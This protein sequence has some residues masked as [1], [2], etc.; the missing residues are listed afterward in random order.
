MKQLH[1][2]S[3]RQR[4]NAAF[5][6]VSL[7]PMLLCS[8]LLLQIFRLRMTSNAQQTAQQQLSAS[9]EALDTLH[10]GFLQTAAS[11]QH[12][13]LVAQAL[14]DAEAEDAAV[15]SQL[16]GA[17]ESVRSFARFDLYDISGRWR[18]STQAAPER[19]SLPT[20]WGLLYEAACAGAGV[21][22]CSAAEDPASTDEPLLRA[23]MLLTDRYGAPVGYLTIG[24]L[25]TQLRTLLGGTAGAQNELLL[26][27][28]RWRPVYCT[29]PAQTQSLADA[30]REQ[31]LSGKALTGLSA[32]ASYTVRQ[33]TETG[34]YLVLQQPQPLSAGTLRL[35]YS[36]SALCALACIIL[37]VVLSLQLSRQVFQPIGRLH[38]AIRQVGKNDL[39]V[40]VPIPAGQ[41]DELGEL[42]QQFNSMVVA[43]RHNQQALLENQRAL[44]RAQI[45]M[46]Q[47]QLNPHFLCNTLDTM[48]WISKINQVPQVAL[49]STNLADILRFCI[50]PDEFVPLKKELEIL[51]RYIEIQRIRLSDSFVYHADVP[52]ELEALMVPKM[53]LQ[54]L[55]E[56]AILHGLEGVEHGEI[57]ASARL[58]PDGTLELCVRD[59]G[60]GLPPELLGPYRPPEKQT[61]HLGL[62][63][64]DT[65]LKKHYG[66]RFGLRLENNTAGGGACIIAVLPA[67]R[68]D[69]QC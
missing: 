48:K 35:L 53:L 50:S 23:A 49:M 29:Q 19:R 56:N 11:L 6:A 4:L 31:L 13:P 2:S 40:Q 8:G 25:E 58:L 17:T 30:L 47:A 54:P 7:V 10:S 44:N 20:N 51:S 18:Y 22:V 3:F 57:T 46:L 5:L 41:H 14:F 62:F 27:D 45:R 1:F 24:M 60:R 16:F 9:C 59:N 69:P 67:G 66:E 28:A 63:N 32:D 61:G 26:L 36:V 15:Y 33:H 34:L 12:D 64:V 38:H 21:L 43:L 65:I 52:Q 42:A 39:D 37:S 55:A 68:R